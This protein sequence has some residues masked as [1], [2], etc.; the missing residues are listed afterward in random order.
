VIKIMYTRKFD[1]ETLRVQQSGGKQP[2]LVQL[3][4]KVRS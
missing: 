4:T 2:N 1:L 3:L